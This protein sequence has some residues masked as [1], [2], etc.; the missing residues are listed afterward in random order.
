MTYV[1]VWNFKSWIL[2]ELSWKHIVFFFFFFKFSK[3][4]VKEVSLIHFVNQFQCFRYT[5]SPCEE[6]PCENGGSCSPSGPD[7]FKCYCDKEFVGLTC[8]DRVDICDLEQPCGQGATCLTTTSKPY[9]RCLCPWNQ[10][11]AQCKEV[12]VIGKSIGF[13]GNG[14]AGITCFFGFIEM[15]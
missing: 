12:L 15:C 4:C 2:F 1:K 7:D 5:K 14:Y 13:N 11:G 3:S 6:N 10:G 8:T 9:Y